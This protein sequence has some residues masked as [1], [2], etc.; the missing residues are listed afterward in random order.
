MKKIGVLT[1]GGDRTARIWE[2]HSGEELVRLEGHT[3]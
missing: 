1:S 2:A 3:S